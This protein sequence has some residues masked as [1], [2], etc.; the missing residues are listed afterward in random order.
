MEAG[1][2]SILDCLSR[3]QSKLP[4]LPLYQLNDE[5][6]RMDRLQ[7]EKGK[8]FSDRKCRANQ[9]RIKVGDKVLMKRMKNNKLDADNI[10]DSMTQTPTQL[11]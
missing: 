6:V 10:N 3:I 4:Q 11:N 8:E 9:S 5:E 1:I 2:K 7:Q